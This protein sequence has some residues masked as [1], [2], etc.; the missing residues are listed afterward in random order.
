[1]Q[2]PVQHAQQAQVPQA[3]VQ[4]QAPTPQTPA[5]PVQAPQM[6]APVQHAQQAQAQAAPAQPA[7]DMS[8]PPTSPSRVVSQRRQA[9]QSQSQPAQTRD[10]GGDEMDE[11]TLL[12]KRK[13][14]PYGELVLP[15]GEVIPLTHR[16][17]LVGRRLPESAKAPWVQAID[18]PDETKTI[19][20]L[21]AKLSYGEGM[22][23][24]EDLNS[25]NGIYVVDE[26]GRETELKGVQRLNSPF[27]LGDV[28]LSVRSERNGA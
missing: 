9:T 15:S 10:T 27:Y 11:R 20:S 17:V 22:W 23:I 2:A 16:T 19:S 28:L 4:P 7:R 26:E 21:H 3:Q 12:A 18:I 13:R 1:M 8:R 6:Q 24:I 14:V 25:T 5:Q